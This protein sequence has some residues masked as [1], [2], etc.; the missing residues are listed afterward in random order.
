MS[1][2]RTRLEAQAAAVLLAGTIDRIKTWVETAPAVTPEQLNDI[3]FLLDKAH[4]FKTTKRIVQ[5]SPEIKLPAED[6]GAANQSE[7]EGQRL[8]NALKFKTQ[9]EVDAMLLG[10]RLIPVETFLGKSIG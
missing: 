10:D 7:W 6:I 3:R 8:G 9:A 5:P 4:E 2:I 1:Q